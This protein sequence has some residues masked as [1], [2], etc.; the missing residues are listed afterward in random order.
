MALWL[1]GCGGD[2]ALDIRDYYF[3]LNSLKEGLVYEYR[4]VADSL[5]GPNYWYYRTIKTDSAIYLAGAYYETDFTPTQIVREELVSNG[6]LLNDLFLFETDT[7]GKQQQVKAEVLSASVFPFSVRDSN[8]IYLYKVRFQMPSQRH[9][10]T[11]LIVNRR[12]MGDTSVVFQ[13]KTYNAI[14]FGLKGVAEVRDSVNGDIEPAFTGHEIYA[15]K[16]GLFS[17]RRNYGG[18]VLQY[19]LHDRYPM[20]Q[21]E[22][23]SRKTLEK[24]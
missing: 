6:M 15:Y 19:Q 17:Y 12:F 7:S 14:R 18:A 9:G 8:D 22:R 1:A 24:K 21:L 11:T 2:Q 13:G 23:M 16:L 10:A 4:P 20:T 5:A 3:P